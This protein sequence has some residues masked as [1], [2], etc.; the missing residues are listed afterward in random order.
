MNIII[1]PHD[2]RRLKELLEI[3]IADSGV[4]AALLVSRSGFALCRA[5]D[6]SDVDVSTLGV[7][8]S[9][10]ASSTQ[11]LANILREKEFAATTYQ[12]T[13]TNMHI[14][15]ISEKSFLVAL[16]DP[17]VTS[18]VVRLY[19]RELTKELLPIV[20]RLFEK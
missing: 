5:G 8:S 18:T 20:H 11:A 15:V 2:G 7:L 12:G 13:H 9:A 16:A 17:S 14:Q 1:E 19:T 10:A 6:F 4:R 3:F